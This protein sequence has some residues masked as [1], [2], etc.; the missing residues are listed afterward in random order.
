MSIDS[1]VLITTY[2]QAFF[3]K[4]GGE[5]ELIEVADNLRQ[6]GI[7]ADIYSPYCCDIN[8]YDTIL[9]F[10]LVADSLPM[11]SYLKS[12]NKRIILWPNFWQMDPLSSSQKSLF[13]QFFSLC[14]AVVFKSKAEKDILAAFIPDTVKILLIP[15]GVDETFTIPTPPDLFRKSFNI[16]NFLLWVGILEPK[17]NQLELIKALSETQL[18]I[19]FIGGARDEQYLEECRNILNSQSMIL[20][21]IEPKSD[22]LKAALQE[23]NLY[24][25]LSSEPAGKSVIEAAISGAN[26]AIPY[27]EWAFEH[28]GDNPVYINL[29]DRTSL[30][31]SILSSLSKKKNMEF[32]NELIERHLL[33]FVLKPLAEYIKS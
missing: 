4:G 2:H 14:D 30:I 6:L 12:L 11:L 5:Y 16:E 9:H 3:H 13:S 25:E 32:A 23:C 28:F 1:K 26:I 17:K 22:M 33:P 8:V 24:I 18:P 31:N 20:P 7:I 27:S 15:A 21:P 29:N 10:S 19:V